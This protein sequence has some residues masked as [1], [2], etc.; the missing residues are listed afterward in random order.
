[1]IYWLIRNEDAQSIN[2]REHFKS[3]I[4]QCVTTDCII[5][6]LL[7]SH[8]RANVDRMARHERIYVGHL[9]RQS[10]ADRRFAVAAG[11]WRL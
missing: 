5:P 6:Q 10:L 7:N 4:R 11:N 1:M 3:V 9:S 2:H 8:S